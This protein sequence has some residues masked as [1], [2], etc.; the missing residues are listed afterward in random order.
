MAFQSGPVFENDVFVDNI[1]DIGFCYSAT[2]ESAPKLTGN[3]YSSGSAIID[4]P[5][6]QIGTADATPAAAPIANAGPIG[7]P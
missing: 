3:F 4:A 6:F 2:A 1:N 5:C 7:L